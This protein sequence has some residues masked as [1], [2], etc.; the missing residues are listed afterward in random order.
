MRSWMP[1]AFALAPT[2]SGCDDAQPPKKPGAASA[3]A[4]SASASARRNDGPRTTL[5]AA[6]S[7]ALPARLPIA[8]LAGDAEVELEVGTTRAHVVAPVGAKVARP[9]LLALAGPDNPKQHCQRWKTISAG[10]PFVVCPTGAATTEKATSADMMDQAKA[11]LAAVKK[12]FGNHV[13]GGRVMVS[14]LGFAGDHVIPLMRQSPGFF[15]HGVIAG[16]GGHLVNAGF[17]KAFAARGG[18]AVL[19]VCGGPDAKACDRQVGRNDVTLR[20][21][22]TRSKLITID[23]LPPAQAEPYTKALRSEWDWLISGHPL[24]RDP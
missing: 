23:G 4:A 19:F 6:P 10:Y 13:A 21:A 17:A 2:L 15:V 5:N 16:S 20:L 14:G 18:Q 3:S 24:W 1:F 7:V 8:P 9:I 12:R 22:G 11:V